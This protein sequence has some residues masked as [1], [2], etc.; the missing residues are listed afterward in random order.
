M[1]TP[2]SYCSAFRICRFVS[3]VCATWFPKHGQPASAAQD[4]AA[5]FSANHFKNW[6]F[7]SLACGKSTRMA[8]KLRPYGASNNAAGAC[9]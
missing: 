2:Q 7:L 3:L 9:G 1:G 4:S 8:A 6:L 5:F